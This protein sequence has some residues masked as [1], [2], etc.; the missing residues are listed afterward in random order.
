[1]KTRP[2]STWRRAVCL[3]VSAWMAA[4]PVGWGQIVPPASAAEGKPEQLLEM[5]WSDAP[6]EVVLDHYAELTGRT[7]IKSPGVPAVLISLKSQE[8]LTESEFLVAIE[9][10]LA[11]NN[12]ALVPMGEKFLKVI[13]AAELGTHG[14]EIAV[15]PPEEAGVR[16]AD[17]MERRI[18]ELQHVQLAEIQPIIDQLKHAYA[19][20]QPLERANSFLITDTKLN[21]DRI[22]EIIDLLDKPVSVKVE[23]R[24]YELRHAQA[25]EVASRLTELIQ[26]SQ[27]APRS[28]T[29]RPATPATR[30]GV[31]RAGTTAARAA[32][33]QETPAPGQ[34]EMDLAQR[35]IVQG[36]VKIVSDERTNI[37]IIISEPVNF[38]FFDQIVTVLDKAVDPEMDVA[39]LALEFADAEEVSGILNDF[40]GAATQTSSRSGSQ[41][42]TAGGAPASGTGEADARSTALREF[43]A[44]RQTAAGTPAAAAASAADTAVAGIGQL[45]ENTRILADTRTN[46]LLL[47][48]R[49]ADIEALRR[50]VDDLDI[51]LSQVMIEAIIIEVSLNENVE[52]GM[53]WLQRSYQVYNEEQRGPGGGYSVRQ[54]VAGFGGAQQFSGSAFI[55]GGGVTRDTA[56]PTGALTY[57]STFYDLNLDV[58]LKLAASSSDARILSTPVIVTTDNTEARIIIG[59]S[60]PIVTSSSTTYGGVDR[61]TYQY[62]DIG[63][64]LTVTPRINPQKFVVMEIV[65]TADNVGGFEVIDGNNV[66]VIT[67]R[68]MEAQIAVANRSSI[69]LGGLIGSEARKSRTKIPILGDIPLLGSLFRS[70]VNNDNRTELM[71]VITP[72]VMASPE[73][74]LAESRRLG[75]RSVVT[76][77]DAWR[78]TWSDSPLIQ[79]RV[80]GEDGGPTP[81]LDLSPDDEAGE[82]GAVPAEA[83]PGETFEAGS[84]D[85]PRVIMR[86]APTVEYRVVPAPEPEAE[87]APEPAGAESAAADPVAA[88]AGS[89]LAAP[90]PR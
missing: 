60:R 29:G 5:R 47:M 62:Q 73:E 61:N 67:R 56:L 51:M 3:F 9:S 81:L 78:H 52:S 65:Q 88:P 82:A 80:S 13:P 71:V 59:E 70:D 64:E 72:Y 15:G 11:M 42:R 32:A 1:M 28:T 18:I 74:T 76:A 66:P 75:D 40:V 7:L 36:E 45:S 54:P 34:S 55:D 12:I 33:A 23:T 4:P 20:I 25:S 86:P 84:G 8:K 35:G 44:R 26:E 85:G 87:P 50:V 89:G 6:L 17:V 57:Y 48:G 41:R 31:I 22:I 37:L 19:K 38:I 68:E 24:I 77:E 79:D 49:R 46:S 43:I 58:V 21:V 53:D 83:G 39:V 27:T 10:M 14:E 30:G 16:A 63:I 69:V 90:V 2:N